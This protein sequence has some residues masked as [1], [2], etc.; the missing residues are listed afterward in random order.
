[1]LQVKYYLKYRMLYTKGYDKGHF[2]GIM[3][4]VIQIASL[5]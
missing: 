3:P 2:L 5:T 1:M 4:T